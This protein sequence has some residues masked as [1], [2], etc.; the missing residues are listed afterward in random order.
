[1]KA[2]LLIPIVFSTVLSITIAF[3]FLLAHQ[4]KVIKEGLTYSQLETKA[5]HHES[6]ASIQS[7][8]QT[9]NKTNSETNQIKSHLTNIGLTIEKLK[10][11]SETAITTNKSAALLTLPEELTATEIKE[12]FHDCLTTRSSS[13]FTTMLIDEL[14][15]E[16]DNSNVPQEIKKYDTHLLAEMGIIF[17]CW[18]LNPPDIRQTN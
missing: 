15:T 3:A 9:I 18:Q 2:S 4:S 10:T 12:R 17:G 7:L 8:K 16:L 11:T 1:M 6:V 5:N 14:M 13:F